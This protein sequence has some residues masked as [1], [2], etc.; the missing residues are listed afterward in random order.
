[1]TERK[2][3]RIKKGMEW[4]RVDLHIHTPASRDFKESGITY[5]QMLQKAESQGLDIVAFTD[6][7]TVAGYARML[8]KIEELE[9]LERMGRLRAEEKRT[10]EEYRRLRQKMLVLPGFEFTATLGFH[11]LGIFSEEMSVR[12]LEHILLRL[13]VPEEKVELGET[14]VGATTDVLNAYRIIAEAEGLVIAAHANS[15]HGV[16][17]QGFGFGGQTKIA[18]TQDPNLHALEVTD[19]ESRK[20]RRTATFF[21]G[22]KPQYPRRMHCIQG[23]DAHR[24]NY[25]P[26]DKNNLGLGD[27]A[28]EI[29]LPDVSFEALKEVF[30]GDDFARTR[31]YRPAE[32]PFDHIGAARQQGPNIVQSF[33]ESLSRKGGRMHAILRDVVAFANTNGGTIYVGLSTNTK[34]KPVGF[35]DPDPAMAEL[36]AEIQRMIT[37]PININIDVQQT[38]GVRVVRVSVPKGTDPPYVLEGSKIYIRQESETSLAMRDEIVSLLKQALLKSQTP[39]PEETLQPPEAATAAEHIQAEAGEP[40]TQLEAPRTGVEIVASV[41]RKDVLYHTMRDLRNGNEVRNVTRTSA[42]K[43]WQYAIA[44]HEKEPLKDAQITWV[45]DVGLWQRYKRAGKVRYDLVGRDADG[46]QHVYYGVTD[47]GIH[48]PWKQLV[49]GD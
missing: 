40:G 27:R 49:G 12:A 2:R 10:L 16:A 23:S 15:N 3:K 25:D 14:E 41:E 19:L 39:S 5:L 43:L 36:H 8:G 28:T 48:G 33:H 31:P 26:N 38:E 24:L 20:R 21:D 35:K 9:L 1:M 22:S 42:R 29:L 11:I 30:L 45:G 44:Q 7:N 6:H 17:M 13:N 4:Q 37:P 34:V 47:D 46:K 18:Y 32:M